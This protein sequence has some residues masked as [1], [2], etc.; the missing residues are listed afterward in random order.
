VLELR[1]WKLQALKELQFSFP[2]ALQWLAVEPLAWEEQRKL[3][4][5]ELEWA[6][7]RVWEPLESKV[8]G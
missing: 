2:P 1:A 5:W 3:L 7:L 8:L 4:V 6:L